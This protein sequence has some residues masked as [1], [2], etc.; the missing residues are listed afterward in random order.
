MAS[1]TLRLAEP[2]ALPLAPLK[3]A[4]LRGMASLDSRQLLELWLGPDNEPSGC[5][6]WL[7]ALRGW[8]E[9]GE[10]RPSEL[11]RHGIGPRRAARLLA[12]LEWVRRRAERAAEPGR[13]PLD[14]AAV[15]HWARPR[16]EGRQHEE[17]WVLCVDGRTALRSAWQVG[18]GGLHGCSLLP[19]DVLAPVLRHAASAFVLVHNHP[20][21]DP[22]P[23]VEDR[24]L[25]R[26]LAK[27]AALVGT[28]LLDH[29]IVA[30]Q[31]F[32]SLAQYEPALLGGV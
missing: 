9:I 21:G 19:R 1:R 11:G 17:V 26:A 4:E 27:A 3:L 25:T 30:G 15:A 7:D 31:R 32:V 16:L 10:L 20:S 6:A 12:A 22:T 28:P 18:R 29:V 23:S 14:A 2:R 24:E 8:A 13:Q 5:D